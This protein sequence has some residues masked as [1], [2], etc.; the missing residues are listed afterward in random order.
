M[1]FE[2]SAAKRL[3]AYKNASG[4]EE[5]FQRRCLFPLKSIKTT[6][7]ISHKTCKNLTLRSFHASLHKEKL[8]DFAMSFRLASAITDTEDT[9]D[10]SDEDYRPTRL[11]GN[12]RR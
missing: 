4:S 5:G 10:G 3:G 9:S 8:K 6:T 7:G 12:T 2:R 11:E 1:V